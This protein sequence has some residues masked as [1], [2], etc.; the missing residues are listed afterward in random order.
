[1]QIDETNFPIEEAWSGE[2]RPPAHVFG[3]SRGGLPRVSVGKPDW[4]PGQVILGKGWQSPAGGQ[5]Y[6][7]ARFK[8]SLRPETSQRIQ[9]A[10]FIVRLEN[11]GGGR[12]PVAFDL[13]PLELKQTRNNAL[14][15]TIGPSL[16]F[17]EVE[18]SL[19]SV[20]TTLDASSAV[21]VIIADGLGEAAVRWTFQSQAHHPLS[22]SRVVYAIIELPADTPSV[23]V[24][25]NLTARIKPTLMDQ[26]TGSIPPNEAANLSWVLGS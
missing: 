5:R 21:P 1:M 11:T 19:G 10:V 7:L 3:V 9:S 15:L 18:A 12:N 17:S 22:G 14:K 6:G 16:K 25:L 23:Q 13:F 4:W 24:S 20:E 2:L 8:F 26:I